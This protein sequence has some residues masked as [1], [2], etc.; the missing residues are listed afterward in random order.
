MYFLSDGE[1]AVKHGPH[2]SNFELKDG[3]GCRAS[4]GAGGFGFP[5]GDLYGDVGGPRVFN[6][7]A[8]G[9]LDPQGNFTEWKPSDK[10]WVWKPRLHVVKEVSLKKVNPLIPSEQR[11]KTKKNK[12]ILSKT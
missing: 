8:P 7:A 4:S 12:N 2:L 5:R 6:I 9:S 10:V 11:P 1:T 3:K